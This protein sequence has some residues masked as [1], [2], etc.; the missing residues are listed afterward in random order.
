MTL[1]LASC[2]DAGPDDADYLA[3]RDIFGTCATCHGSQ[4]EGGAG[5]A[6]TSVLET[7]PTCDEH[8]QWVKLGSVRWKEEVGDTYGATDQ[9]VDGAMPSFA[10]SLTPEE[11]QQIVVYERVRFGEADLASEKAACGLD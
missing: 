6:L 4:G 8:Q 10:E 11:I 9:V 1:G 3:G 7:F 5:P 2:V